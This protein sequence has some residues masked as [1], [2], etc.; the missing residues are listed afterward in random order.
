MI[1]A[2]TDGLRR[3][4]KMIPL[5]TFLVLACVFLYGLLWAPPN[6][7]LIMIGISFGATVVA[8]IVLTLLEGKTKND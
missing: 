6:I 3:E 7:R 8:G 5:V 1:K 2:Y 4:P